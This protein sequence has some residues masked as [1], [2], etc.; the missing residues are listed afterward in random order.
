MT[1]GISI[2]FSL[3]F[4]NSE[5]QSEYNTR[6]ISWADEFDLWRFRS[7]E[8]L[9]EIRIRKLNSPMHLNYLHQLWGKENDFYFFFFPNP[10]SFKG[11]AR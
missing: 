1:H 9:K 2:D 6:K 7:S 3:I 5:T 10:L 11:T 4:Q 8:I